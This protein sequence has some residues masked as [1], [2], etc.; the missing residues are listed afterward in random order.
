VNPQSDGAPPPAGGLEVRPGLVLPE[1]ELEVRATRSGGPGGQNV[2]KVSTRVELRFDVASSRVL[3]DEEKALVRAR[4]AGRT[5]ARGVLR[6]VSQ[7][8]RSRA[9]NEAAARRRLAELL[10]AALAVAPPR[11]ATRPT[12]AARRRR[13][14]TK[15]RRAVVKRTRRPLPR[16]RD[17]E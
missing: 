8:E 6:V 11:R 13:S 3:D 12:A 1:D 4:L 7:R 17:D 16:H 5:S 2:N 9:R 15:R 14:E 10:A